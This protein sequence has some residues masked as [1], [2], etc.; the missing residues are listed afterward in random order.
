VVTRV[1]LLAMGVALGG[2]SL[3]IDND[4]LV[5]TGDAGGGDGGSVDAG[6]RPDAG[7]DDAGVVDDAGGVDAGQGCIEG[8]DCPARDN[9]TVRCVDRACEYECDDG[10][11]DCDGDPSNGCERD[12]TSSTEHCGECG[13]GCAWS[14][15]DSMCDDPASL[16]GGGTHTC[17]VLTSGRVAC[18][19]D[20]EF[21]QI[22]NDDRTDA[23]RPTVLPSPADAEEA[24]AGGQTTCIRT[25]AGE[26]FCWG[27][28]AADGHPGAEDTLTPMR[29]VG[30]PTDVVDIDANGVT[31]VTTGMDAEAWCWGQDLVGAVGDGGGFVTDDS[32]AMVLANGFGGYRS[33][34]VGFFHAGSVTLSGGGAWWG[35]NR[36]R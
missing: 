19:G 28:G 17:A 18:W 8:S 15:V 34:G 13:N 14:C 35:G 10:F 6:A 16:S 21:G 2:C 32:V 11:G 27:D 7:A 31:C 20:N 5:G 36:N 24:A 26:V 3:L 12:V 1:L 22:G 25:T 9:A 30:L 33:V 29:L 23:L 4:A